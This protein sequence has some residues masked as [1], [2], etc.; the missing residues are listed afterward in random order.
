VQKLTS[1]SLG[2]LLKGTLKSDLEAIGMEIDTYREQDKKRTRKIMIQQTDRQTKQMSEM[3]ML[4]ETD[5]EASQA[6]DFSSG[7]QSGHHEDMKSSLPNKC[8]NS[9]PL[10]EKGFTPLSDNS[11]IMDMKNCHLSV[12]SDDDHCHSLQRGVSHEDG[13]EF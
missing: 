5:L 3:S 1:R 12:S 10:W 13:E 11:D 6:N 4:S 9:D 8:P 7:H 2:R